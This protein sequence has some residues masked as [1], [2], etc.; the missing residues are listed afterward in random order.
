MSK[1]KLF[2]R[3]VIFV[4][5]F[6]VLFSNNI[7]LVNAATTAVTADSSKQYTDA[8]RSHLILGGGAITV[9]EGNFNRLSVTADGN[10]MVFAQKKA[11]SLYDRLSDS[12]ETVYTSDHTLYDAT[13][14]LDGSYIVFKEYAGTTYKLMG[15][16]VGSKELKTLNTSTKSFFGFPNLSADGSLVSYA[17]YNGTKYVGMLQNTTTLDTN[18]LDPAKIGKHSLDV[19]STVTASPVIVSHDGKSVFLGTYYD[20]Y[21][22][23]GYV[24]KYDIA[25]QTYKAISG[26]GADGI[27]LGY[28]TND[29][30]K[31]FGQF[32]DV[33]L[34]QAASMKSDG[35]NKQVLGS[36]SSTTIKLRGINGDGS[37][38]AN[39]F[40][41]ITGYD[42]RLQTN[43]NS[44]SEIIGGS[45][46]ILY[47]N[48][49]KGLAWVDISE[50]KNNLPSRLAPYAIND[51]TVSTSLGSKTNQLK[52]TPSLASSN[53]NVIYRNDVK[54]GTVADAQGS[55]SDSTAVP[56]TE[57]TYRL[58]TSNPSGTA[59]S[60]TTTGKTGGIADPVNVKAVVTSRV[61][62]DVTADAVALATGYRLTVNNVTLESATPTFA[63]TG[64]TASTS[65][66]AKMIAYNADATSNA[67]SVTFKTLDTDPVY[68]APTGLYVMDQTTTSISLEWPTVTGATGY[69]LK[70]GNTVVYDGTNTAYTNTTLTPATSYLYTVAAKFG[71]G[72]S[73]AVSQ[74]GK[75]LAGEALAAPTNFTAKLVDGKVLLTFNAVPGATG[76]TIKRGDTVL[77]SGDS[78]SIT[79]A[80]VTDGN[81]YV[82][83]VTATDG[84]NISSAASTSIA[85]TAK[86]ELA[87]PSG[88]KV[89][90]NA[91]NHTY[92]VWDKV[93]GATSYTLRVQ[94]IDLVQTANGF[95]DNLSIKPLTTYTYELL[96]TDGSQSSKPV[97][98][99]IT[100]PAE[101]LAYPK[102]L[103][104]IA[105]TYNSVTMKFTGVDDADSYDVYLNDMLY[106]TI[107]TTS[108]TDDR[109]SGGATNKYSYVA[110]KGDLKSE[111]AV[112][113]VHVPNK[114]IAG[115]AP[116]A[117]T[118]LKAVQVAAGYVKLQSLTV[119]KATY[120]E[121][122]RDDNI[123]VASGYATAIKDDTVAPM[124]TYTYTVYAGNTFG[125]TKGETISVTTPAEAPAIVIQPTN[126]N[127]SYTI[128]FDFKVI[129]DADTIRVERNPEVTYKA[130]G[131]GEYHKTY[132]NTV[133]RETKDL[134][135]VK[136]ENGLL[137]FTEE[138]VTPATE[139]KYTITAIKMRSNGTEEVV[140]GNE[141]AVTTPKDGSPATVSNNISNDNHNSSANG[142]NG[143]NT[144][145]TP[146]PT[147]QGTGSTKKD[148][149][150]KSSGSTSNG[151]TLP[152]TSIG[153]NGGADN[154]SETGGSGSSNVSSN[155]SSGTSGS[156]GSND[157]TYPVAHDQSSASFTDVSNS[158]FAKAAITSLTQAG[159]IKGYE[160][161]T[162][163]P[164]LPVTRAE[165]AIMIVRAF[166]LQSNT[167]YQH[168]FVDFNSSAWYAPEL[169]IALNEGVTKGYTADRYAPSQLIPREQSAMMLMNTLYTQGLKMPTGK[170]SYADAHTVTEWARTSVDAAIRV[171]IMKGYPDGMF[172]PHQQVT[173]AE[174]VVMIDAAMH[175]QLK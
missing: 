109:V 103:T 46:N 89:V 79:D 112:I 150:K 5:S 18:V 81:T 77:S 34:Y 16:S 10:K 20:S 88:F 57:Y 80:N 27:H 167:G 59:Q 137:R 138:G 104:V 170:V 23:L 85:L 50:I 3:S 124:Q 134:G 135:L 126:S 1:L 29:D 101:M 13:I 47:Y 24:F 92:L 65:Y 43:S 25:A 154:V 70:R 61:T 4:L 87:S 49:P 128:N 93:S 67:V 8:T 30:S 158:H 78:R 113:T 6:V 71:S 102:N 48:G 62:A 127:E 155:V 11:I 12:Q 110:R 123:K 73:S 26:G 116:A 2:K 142:N 52:W 38:F 53:A 75:T 100:T 131:N 147:Q 108:F 107:T 66:T 172:K 56:G 9:S 60:N 15:Y 136:A 28:L 91:F 7:Q 114:T 64:L 139:Y 96:A 84:T 33:Q 14:S 162:F 95:Y 118:G 169:A 132:Y 97:M 174:A 125:R 99:T 94:G 72:I 121:Y 159:V 36:S 164:D 146:M 130:L 106:A 119:A 51:L 117:P 22:N 90:T 129:Q 42:F 41:Y 54:I 160:D 44:S 105:A 63:V 69:V 115:E 157:S 19:N 148:D 32:Y 144:D 168:H 55:Y 140:G 145:T 171:A 98:L 175:I 58:E 166:D 156:G 68:T 161:G 122:F 35:S 17:F 120:Y 21:T 82:Y 153:N 111:P 163:H 40:A 39:S 173:R 45:S 152:S 37:V 165:F 86:S 151:S 133:T 74:M 31:I 83:T 143:G 141:V 76:Y 149:N